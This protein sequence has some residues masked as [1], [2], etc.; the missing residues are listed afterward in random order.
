MDSLFDTIAASGAM[1][2]EEMNSNPV[3]CYSAIIKASTKLSKKKQKV[4][5]DAF[6]K[7]ARTGRDVFMENMQTKVEGIVDE[8]KKPRGNKEDKIEEK[9]V[10]KAKEKP[11]PA[12]T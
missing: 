11:E 10:E 6:G 9:P 5:S 12:A 1:T 8:I 7:L 2:I 4:I 3:K